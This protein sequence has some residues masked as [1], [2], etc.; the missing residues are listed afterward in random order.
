MTKT[1]LDPRTRVATLRS[2]ARKLQKR[3]RELLKQSE[4]EQSPVHCAILHAASHE[5]ILF[6]ADLLDEARAI[7][8]AERG[9]G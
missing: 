2:V 1:A 5:L 6:G 8:R 4:T 7:S 3:S 9:T